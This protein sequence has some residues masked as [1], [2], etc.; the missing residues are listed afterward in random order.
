MPEVNIAAHELLHPLV[1]EF[2]NKR[3]LRD[4]YSEQVRINIEKKGALIG[5][6]YSTPRFRFLRL[7][8]LK[9]QLEI[10]DNQLKE[11]DKLRWE[12][13]RWIGSNG[14][15]IAKLIKNITNEVINPTYDDLVGN[16][17]LPKLYG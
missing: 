6:I 5:L 17:E 15:P 12:S 13:F 2:F 8:Q 10:T 4:Y 11:M 14:G 7:K 9:Q 1:V 16:W 3:K